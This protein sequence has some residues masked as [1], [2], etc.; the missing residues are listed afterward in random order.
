MQSDMFA[1]LPHPVLDELS[2]LDL[3]DLTPRRATRNGSMH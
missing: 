2:K 3:D 1:S